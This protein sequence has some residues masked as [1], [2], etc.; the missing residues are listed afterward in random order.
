LGK[1]YNAINTSMFSPHNLH[2]H[3]VHRKTVSWSIFNTRVLISAYYIYLGKACQGKESEGKAWKVIRKVKEMN[4]MASDKSRHV[5][6]RKCKERQG[7]ASEGKARQGKE[8]KV[9]ER[10]GK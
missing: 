1:Y 3:F 5:R 2:C 8:R 6:K 7:K 10:N 4:D 9:K